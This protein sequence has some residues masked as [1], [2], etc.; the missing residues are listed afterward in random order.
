M[1]E[2][3]DEVSFLHARAVISGKP[4]SIEEV[5]HN[6]FS[7]HEVIINEGIPGACEKAF[8]LEPAADVFEPFG[9][10]FQ[11]V[12]HHDGLSVQEKCPVGRIF[13][14]DLKQLIQAFHQVR[15]KEFERLAP[16]AIPVCV[17]YHMD[18]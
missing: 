4:R 7:V 9:P 10:G 16:F 17:G 2:G 15:L 12:F 5:S 14:K 6:G 13:F 3:G 1:P 8:L 11:V 18:L